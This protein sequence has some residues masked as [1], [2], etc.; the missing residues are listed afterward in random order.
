MGG[1][2]RNRGIGAGGMLIL[3]KS[4]ISAGFQHLKK[5]SWPAMTKQKSAGPL[6]VVGPGE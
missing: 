1:K 3:V 5:C 2:K 6:D 4:W